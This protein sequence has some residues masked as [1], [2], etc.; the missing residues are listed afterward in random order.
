M[1]VSAA[2]TLGIDVVPDL[3][4]RFDFFQNRGYSFSMTA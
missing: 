1:F 2:K 3:A 4:L